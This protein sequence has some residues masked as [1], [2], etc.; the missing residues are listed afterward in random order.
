[1]LTQPVYFIFCLRPIA[2]R[3]PWPSGERELQASGVITQKRIVHRQ[4]IF[5]H[6]VPLYY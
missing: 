5:N 1:M 6:C 3:W 2:R 4:C